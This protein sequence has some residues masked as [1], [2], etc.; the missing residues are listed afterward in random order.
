MA[1]GHLAALLVSRPD[2]GRREVQRAY[3]LVA[4]YPERGE[5]EIDV[6][7]HQPPG[8]ATL[9]FG[10]A[11]VG[12]TISTTFLGSRFRMPQPEPAGYLLVGDACS[13]PAI[14][15]ILAAARPETPIELYLEHSQPEQLH[16]PLATHPRLSLQRVARSSDG[17]LAA[18]IPRRE[19][20]GWYAWAAGEMA[21]MKLLHKELRTSH[22]FGKDA[23]HVQSYWAEG[24]KTH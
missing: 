9:W 12:A 10:Q 6:L 24:T 13:T 15:N 2:G 7:M 23:M 11:Q 22:G 17:S 14:N 18:A 20:Q 16:I 3:T 1:P 21:S 8:P 4:A 5:V 19:R